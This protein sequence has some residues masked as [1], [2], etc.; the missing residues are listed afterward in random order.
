MIA[1]RVLI[2]SLFATVYKVELFIFIGLHW[3][4]MTMWILFMV[5]KFLRYVQ[6]H[7]MQAYFNFSYLN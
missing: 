5:T 2:M 7:K 1:S 3:M 6:I 4:L